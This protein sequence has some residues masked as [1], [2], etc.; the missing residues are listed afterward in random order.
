MVD[1][2][3]SQ[4]SFGVSAEGAPPQPQLAGIVIFFAIAAGAT[5]L[6]MRK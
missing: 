1:I 3:D 6:A 5:W 2:I 4:V